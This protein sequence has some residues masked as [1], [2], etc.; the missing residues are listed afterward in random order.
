MHAPFP[1]PVTTKPGFG[2]FGIVRIG[3]VQAS[4]GALVMAAIRRK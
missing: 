4:I 1:A 2:W 3:L